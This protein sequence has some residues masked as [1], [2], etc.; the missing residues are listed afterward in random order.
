MMLNWLRKR[1]N[2]HRLK[3]IAD[4][5]QGEILDIGCSKI[6]NPYLNPKK[7]I[8]VDLDIPENPIYSVIQSD[9]N[10]KLPFK[11][12]M[13]DTVTAGEILEH[14]EN[15]LFTLKEIYRILKPGGAL[16]VTIP[17]GWLD[18]F[19]MYLNKSQEHIMIFCPNLFFRIL[20]EA[21]FKSIQFKRITKWYYFKA[22]K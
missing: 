14:L 13:F 21:N 5:A 4:K 3:N 17:N 2:S 20:K 1:L 7:T 11:E 15:P 10:E 22:I 16:I 18:M 9:L 12:A 8:G 19:M 6:Q